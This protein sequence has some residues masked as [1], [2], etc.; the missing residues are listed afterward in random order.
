MTEITLNK[1]KYL[2]NNEEFPIYDHPQYTS[3]LLRPKVGVLE[4]EI[5]LINDL[6]EIFNLNF[7]L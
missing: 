5:G 3:I 6:N 4:K 2:V 1:K 7:H